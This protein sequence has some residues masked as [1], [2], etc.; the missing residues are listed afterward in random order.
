MVEVQGLGESWQRKNLLRESPFELG[1]KVEQLRNVRKIIFIALTT[2]VVITSGSI[3][4]ITGDALAVLMALLAEV[5]L[6]VGLS[7]TPTQ[8][9]GF[10]VWKEFKL[11]HDIVVKELGIRAASTSSSEVISRTNK[12]LKKKIEDLHKE[13]QR[14]IVGGDEISVPTMSEANKLHDEIADYWR[15]YN[16]AKYLGLLDD[17]ISTIVVDSTPAPVVTGRLSRGNL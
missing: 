17:E 2:I 7:D 13:L 14:Y 16:A 9:H 4:L 5:C 1:R 15:F 12:R 10:Q 6:I 3:T 8:K 11:N